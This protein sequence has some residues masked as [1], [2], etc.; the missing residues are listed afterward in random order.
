[1]IERL[2]TSSTSQISLQI[3]PLIGQ[4]EQ[5]RADFRSALIRAIGSIRWE[6]NPGHQPDDFPSEALPTR[7]LLNLSTSIWR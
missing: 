2:E 4:I 5:I 7:S 1:M 6:A 3:S